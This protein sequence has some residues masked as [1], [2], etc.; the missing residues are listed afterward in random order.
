MTCPLCSG[1]LVLSTLWLG[2]ALLTIYH[3]DDTV[4]HRH[5]PQPPD[6]HHCDCGY[7]WTTPTA[8]EP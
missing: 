6:H 1:S 8:E 2:P 5:I 3:E 4:E 7:E